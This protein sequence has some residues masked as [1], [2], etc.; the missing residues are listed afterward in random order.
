MSSL[1]VIILTKN[2][3]IHLARALDCL[4]KTGLTNEIYVIDS[5]ST[6]RTRQIA[7]DCGATF[8]QHVYTNQAQQL[9]WALDSIQIESDWIMRLDADEIL[10]EDLCCAIGEYLIDAPDDVCGINLQR[11][12][13]F[14]GRWIKHGGRYPLNLLRV[15]R[16]GK[17]KVQNRWMDEHVVIWGGKIVTLKGCFEDRNLNDISYFIEKH[18]SYAN[19][20]AVSVLMERYGLGELEPLDDSTTSRQAAFKSWMKR[21]VYNR[22]P[23][24]LSSTL[25]FVWRYVFQLGFLDGIEGLAYHFLQGYWYRF[26]VGVRI[27][28]LE[29]GLIGVQGKEQQVENLAHL[30]GLVIK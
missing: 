27:R 16:N 25:Y 9:Q 17:G 4:L 29:A 2:E 5:Y 26:L 18:N 11:R 6:D 24:Q 3:E 14:M 10:G 22:I 21:R 1:A 12:H 30:S 23:F 28:E 20:E 19:R 13:I 15:W 8:I 7:E